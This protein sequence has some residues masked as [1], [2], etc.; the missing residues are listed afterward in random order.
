MAR[1]PTAINRRLHK[2]ASSAFRVFRMLTAHN[3]QVEEGASEPT[4]SHLRSVR[5]GSMQAPTYQVGG[6]MKPTKNLRQ[7]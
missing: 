7:K 1:E 2:K 6:K 4:I 5:N 3:S